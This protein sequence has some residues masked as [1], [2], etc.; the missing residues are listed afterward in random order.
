VVAGNATVLKGAAATVVVVVGVEVAGLP[1]EN[2]EVAVVAAGA[3]GVVSIDDKTGDAT[4]W[5]GGAAV[6][7]APVKLPNIGLC[8]GWVVFPKEKPDDGAAAAAGSTET[9]S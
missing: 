5:A 6:D 8:T 3:A 4:V 2:P 1:N 9:D 7:P